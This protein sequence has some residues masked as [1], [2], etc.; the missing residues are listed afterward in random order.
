MPTP[1]NPIVRLSVALICLLILCSSSVRA[2]DTID[3]KLRPVKGQSLKLQATVNQKVTNT[4][5]GGAEQTMTQVIGLGYTFATLDVAPDG[6]ATVKVTY[7]TV[8]FKQQSQLSTVEYDSANPPAGPIPPLVRGF[9][10][11]AGQ[12]FTMKVTP[13]GKITEVLGL[14]EM[15]DAILKKLDTPDAANRD[16]VEKSIRREFGPEALKENMESMLAN[17]PDKPVAVGESWNK[18][19]SITK[20]FRMEMDNTFTLKSVTADT[21]TLD[22]KGKLGSSPDA[23]P[24]DMG[25]RGKLSYNLNG[26][27]NGTLQLD[28]ATGWVKSAEM[29]QKVTGEMVIDAGGG[30]VAK[31]PMRIESTV[32]LEAK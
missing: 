16:V 19:L 5:N 15:I 24:I 31:T 20:G 7:D 29:T 17:Y 18:K 3:L 8:S 21:V 2:A 25:P 26:E 1:R 11:L 14:D 13:T 10:A 6:T 9:A 32:K 28:R 4:V 22:A 23:T 27:Q 12:T 30:R